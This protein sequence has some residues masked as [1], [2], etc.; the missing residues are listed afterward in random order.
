M[1]ARITFI[2]I[3]TPG[4]N[5]AR[6]KCPAI[7]T[8]AIGL[9]AIGLAIGML[10]AMDIGTGFLAHNTWRSTHIASLTITSIRSGGIDTLG[11]LPTNTSM[12]AALINVH[13]TGAHGLKSIQAEALILN[14]LGIVGTIEIRRTLDIDI[15][16]FTGCLGIR[17]PG[18][19]LGTRTLITGLFIFTNGMGTTGFF[20]GRTFVDVNA[21]AEGI[22]G[23]F[24]FTGADKTSNGVS[25]NGIFTTGIVLAFIDICRD[26][27]GGLGL[28][29]FGKNAESETSLGVSFVVGESREQSNCVYFVGFV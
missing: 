14:T 22:T 19:S 25:A 28:Y 12:G 29:R 8:D 18:K 1:Y 6:V 24:R 4:S 27:Y 21:T 9:I 13:T 11:M 15:N 2:D 20:H 10:A 23:K 3:H 7:F 17:F 5:I 16:L 26:A